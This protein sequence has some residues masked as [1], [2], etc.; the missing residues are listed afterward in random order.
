[1]KTITFIY[2]VLIIGVLNADRIDFMKGEGL[3]T[4][5]PFLILSSLAIPMMLM[6]KGGR[7]T[8]TEPS[9]SYKH[10]PGYVGFATVLILL[11]FLSAL[12][13]LDPVQTLKRATLLGIITITCYFLA[14]GAAKHADARS[15]L[16]TGSLIG[17]LL[18][19][20]LSFLQGVNF[21]AGVFDP[22]QARMG[23][24]NLV[25]SAI[26]G[27][28]SRISGYTQ[29]SNRMAMISILY[30]TL[31]VMYDTSRTRRIFTVFLGLLHVFG[32]LSRSGIL[33]FIVAVAFNIQ[34]ARSLFKS[35]FAL[36]ATSIAILVGVVSVGYYAIVVLNLVNPMEVLDNRF[37]TDMNSSAGQRVEI[38][39]IAWEVLNREA[40]HY[41]IGSGFGSSYPYLASIFEGHRGSNYHNLI[42]AAFTELG[43]LGGLSMLILMLFPISQRPWTAKLIIPLIVFNLFYEMFLDPTFWFVI[44]LI[45][46]QTSNPASVPNQMAES[47]SEGPLPARQPM[48]PW[49]QAFRRSSG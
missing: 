20:G 19:T 30:M 35:R 1:M 37:A 3:F 47:S 8:S 21:F 42:L 4:L 45:W 6:A 39:Y 5:T 44:A 48:L 28:G 12:T 15:I 16:G 27:A 33:A 38:Y 18:S 23:I 40:A 2:Y 10:S 22:E 41:A 13:S 11:A 25:P 31:S 43:L 14:V 46:I 36:A 7:R 17:L 9:L 49:R 24:L 32:S 34:G 26:E 29:D